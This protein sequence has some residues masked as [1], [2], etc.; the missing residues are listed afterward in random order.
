MEEPGRK[1]VVI[2]GAA[3]VGALAFRAIA[4]AL[5]LSPFVALLILWAA[6]T[7]IWGAFALLRARRGDD[8]DP[9]G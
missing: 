2:G 4:D 9:P 3:L 6:L 5:D 8:E 1:L 7:L